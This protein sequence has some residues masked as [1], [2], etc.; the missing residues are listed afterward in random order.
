MNASEL[1]ARLQLAKAGEPPPVE[2]GPEEEERPTSRVPLLD[3]PALAAPLPPL[4]FLVRELGLTAGSGAPHLV[5]GYGFVGKTLVMQGLL[6][7]LA[8]GRAVWGV[9]PATRRRVL[10]V[11]LE[12][13]ARLTT[14][15]YQRLAAATGV[16][17][18]SV[19]DG[20]MVAAMPRI[21]LT[22][23][24]TDAW[25]EL[26]AGRELIVVDSL[27]AAAGGADEN[28]STIRGCLDMLG[29]LSEETGCRA[30]VIVH[31]R[32]PSGE[33]AGDA[34]YSI[35]GSSAIY[36]A[37]DAVYVLSAA[38]GE[39]ILLEQAKAREVGEPIEDLCLVIED[40]TSGDDA[41]A[42]VRIAVHGAEL[43]RERREAAETAKADG[44]AKRDAEALRAAIAANP[45]LGTH[46]IRSAAGLSGVR[47]QAA[48][49]ILGN[50]IELREER[51]GRTT[52]TTH[53]LRGAT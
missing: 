18:A 36:D 34:R 12:Q 30:L 13:G 51:R 38:K 8:A 48:L 11:D 21:R 26:M 52:A 39:P 4:E 41:K 16:D 50:A 43:V 35:R 42:G 44:K 22:A 1:R 19:G 45:G 15:R 23:E 28:D 32:K 53:Y 3:G 31:A 20:L 14:R 47:Y 33:D 10:H 24:H 29:M 5:A 2:W 49:A 46:A 37:C 27:R 25:R 9:Y 7:S 40:V 17:L 6:L